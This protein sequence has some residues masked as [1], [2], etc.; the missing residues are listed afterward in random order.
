M[1][2]DDFQPGVRYLREN[3]LEQLIMLDIVEVLAKIELEH[4]AICAVAAIVP[5][6][7][8]FE[9][10]ARKRDALALETRTIIVDHVALEHWDQQRLTECLLGNRVAYIQ[11]AHE[12]KIAA[13]AHLKC[14]SLA[15]AI[16]RAL[17]LLVERLHFLEEIDACFLCRAFPSRYSVHSCVC[18]NQCIVV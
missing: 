4:I 2:Q 17:N 3:Q 7:V 13:L 12:A 16:R 11:R 5:A 9:A 8:L 10:T 6:Q 15:G 1:L 14:D 18:C